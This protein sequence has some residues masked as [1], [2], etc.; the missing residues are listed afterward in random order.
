[1]VY[2][3]IISNSH[4]KLCDPTTTRTM[5]MTG[6]VKH[7]LEST[8]FKWRSVASLHS[9]IA[10]NKGIIQLSFHDGKMFKAPDRPT[11]PTDI[12]TGN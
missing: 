3:Y 9:H 5:S 12:Q 2:V 4:L 6:T 7:F 10:E 11:D 8:H 1:M